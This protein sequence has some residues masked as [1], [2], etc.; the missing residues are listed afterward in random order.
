MLAKGTKVKSK[1]ND[2]TGVAVG[3]FHG[4]LMIIWDNMPF[5]ASP[6]LNE[7]EVK[8]YE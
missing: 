4:I 3:Y 2:W 5:K 8:K 6:V 7:N 1:N